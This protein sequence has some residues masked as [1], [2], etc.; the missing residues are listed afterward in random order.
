[1]KLPFKLLPAVT[2]LA[3][4]SCSKTEIPLPNSAATESAAITAGL[5]GF[6]TT[7]S[8]YLYAGYS[9]N[10]TS[11]STNCY[12]AFSEP[13]VDL[14]QNWNHYALGTSTSI[15][16]DDPA[17]GNISMGKVQLSGNT[18]LPFQVTSVQR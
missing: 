12:A 16:A 14:M 17:R 15:P 1:M 13:D 8:G 18:L 2:V 4:T 7:L 11:R 5:P 10:G 6:R 9:V 3:I